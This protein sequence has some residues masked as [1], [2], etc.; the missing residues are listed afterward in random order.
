[1]FLSPHD[2]RLGC[3]LME[4]YISPLFEKGFALSLYFGLYPHHI[5][6][7]VDSIFNDTGLY[8]ITLCFGMKRRY[9]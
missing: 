1:M 2:D 4:L 3:V 9:S 8:L 6:T 7:A 5:S